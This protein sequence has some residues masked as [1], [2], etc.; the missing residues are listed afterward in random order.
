[1]REAV[2]FRTSTCRLDGA[3]GGFSSNPDLNLVTVDT[4]GFLSSI[5][6]SPEDFGLA[7]G[8]DPCIDLTSVCANPNEFVFYDGIHVTSATHAA[9]AQLAGNR[10]NAASVPE[11]SMLLGSGTIALWTISRKRRRLSHKS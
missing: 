1:M 2:R 4:F 9:F 10:L 8:V 11:P 6:A 7:N 5:T 3:L